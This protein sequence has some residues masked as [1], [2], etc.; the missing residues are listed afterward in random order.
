MAWCLHA[1]TCR[2]TCKT[3]LK[4]SHPAVSSTARAGECVCACN[5]D[6]LWFFITVKAALESTLPSTVSNAEPAGS[7]IHPLNWSSTN[8]VST[9]RKTLP[10]LMWDFLDSQ[11]ALHWMHVQELARREWIWQS[12][13]SFLVLAQTSWRGTYYHLRYYCTCWDKLKKTGNLI[14]SPAGRN[15]SD[16]CGPKSLCA[17]GF[18]FILLF[19]NI[20]FILFY[21][22]ICLQV[23]LN[24]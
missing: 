12:R 24:F 1:C 15:M 5:S 6:S 21:L 19:F 2:L 10:W 17:F 9:R 16:T 22:F 8:V 18:Y 11:A 23:T 14:W 13:L 4:Y 7:R 20:R 3:D